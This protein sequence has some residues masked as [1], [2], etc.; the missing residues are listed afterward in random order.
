MPCS[1]G[2]ISEV[3]PEIHK[4]EN[5]LSQTYNLSQVMQ[6]SVFRSSKIIYIHVYIRKMYWVILRFRDCKL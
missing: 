6:F 1:S 2:I 3:L 4:M 5:Y